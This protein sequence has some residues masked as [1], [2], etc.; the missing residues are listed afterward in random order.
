MKLATEKERRLEL[1]YMVFLIIVGLLFSVLFHFVQAFV[2]ELNFYPYNTFLFLPSDRFN[3]F[4]NIYNAT[5]DLDPF[6]AAVSVYPP[7]AYIVMYPFTMFKQYL[8]L[9]I[10]L[11]GF[12]LF[13]WRYVYRTVS[14]IDA[15]RRYLK[16]IALTFM[17]YPFLFAFDRAN[18]EILVFIF[19]ALFIY[20]H[21]KKEDW[22]SILCLACAIS[23]K[24][25][26][27]AFL[28]LFLADKKYKNIFY[29]LLS[30]AG[31]TLISMLVLKGGVME[32][33][34]GF[35]NNMDIFRLEYFFNVSGLH[36]NLSLFGVLR[37]AYA[38]FMPG[39]A[40]SELTYSIAMIA[41]FVVISFYLVFVEKEFWRSVTIIV[42]YFLVAPQISFD[43][44]LLHLFI[45]I[46]LF[47]DRDNQTKCPL[48]FASAFALL[49][50]PKDYYLLSCPVCFWKDISISVII[51]PLISLSVMV[52]LIYQGC[53]E[54]KLLF[55]IRRA[56]A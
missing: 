10:M 1:N 43:Y 37:I 53:Q 29:T 18:I 19:S 16:T 2:F 8:A 27:G 33:Y 52:V 7:F 17:T 40:F 25:Y 38:Y 11:A 24:I 32:S 28:L 14:G 13:V 50:I 41:L 36:H 21:Q 20:F 22:K 4:N 55:K 34:Y 44:K 9:A 31:L 3:D 54:N 49:C 26:P 48:F 46:T 5:V 6:K 45:P 35:I 56:L 23:M 39:I 42:L 30:V 15:Q 47:L 51:N 12:T